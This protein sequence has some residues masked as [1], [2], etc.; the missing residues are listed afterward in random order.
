MEIIRQIDQLR[1]RLKGQGRV[2]FVPTM[3]YL[4]AGHMSLVERCIKENPISV[5]SIFVNPTQFGPNMDLDRYPRDMERDQAL[6]EQAGVDY[7]FYPAVEAIYPP[8]F[9]T[10]TEVEGLTEHLDGASRPGYFRGICT[11]VLKLFNIVR[12]D[13]AYFG[14]KDIQQ[15]LVIRRMIADLHLE[16]DL[17]IMP[18]VREPEGLAM[19]SRNAYLNTEERETALLLYRSLQVAKKLFDRGETRAAVVK[20]QVRQL[21][22]SG[23]GITVDYVEVVDLQDVQPVESL[24]HGGCVAI[25]V[26]L[27]GTR[28]IDNIILEP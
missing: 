6:L 23:D 14:Q 8:G 9:A 10:W 13:V 12:P 19:S 22:E 17:T 26:D 5:V 25:A 24:G 7:L 15:A 16:I 28:L 1:Q 11:V 4:H 2:G 3:G 18:T 21:L 27:N 20:Q